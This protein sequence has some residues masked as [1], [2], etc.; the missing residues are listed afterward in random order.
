[1]A[2]SSNYPKQPAEAMRD[3]FY[4]TDEDFLRKCEKQKL[5]SGTTALCCLYRPTE[6]R[7]YVGW[8]GDSKALLVTQ[9]N[10][11]QMVKPHKPDS[12]VSRQSQ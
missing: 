6:K 11:M 10:I 8:L 12:P 7:L 4:R 5:I 9:G 2:A 3:A 1:M